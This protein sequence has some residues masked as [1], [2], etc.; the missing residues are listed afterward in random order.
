M[1]QRMITGSG[2]LVYLASRENGDFGYLNGRRVRRR[3]RRRV[4]VCNTI[5][6]CGS[7]LTFS[8]WDRI[9]CRG[10]LIFHPI[11]SRLGTIFLA[12]GLH[13]H[14]RFRDQL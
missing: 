14:E 10:E 2:R 6:V 9:V 13:R 8:L 7:L 3:A 4:R 11:P 12:R 1:S 5:E